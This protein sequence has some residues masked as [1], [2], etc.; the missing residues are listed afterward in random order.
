[1][2]PAAYDDRRR[3][4]QLPRE[5]LR[6]YQFGRLSALLAEVMAHNRF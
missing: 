6:E 4:E 3:M 1:M 5:K 2:L